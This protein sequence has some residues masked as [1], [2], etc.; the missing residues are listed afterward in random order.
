MAEIDPEQGKS[1]PIRGQRIDRTSGA[2]LP[3]LRLTAPNTGDAIR[4]TEYQG[5][6]DVQIEPLSDTESE[7][8]QIDL[9]ATQANLDAASRITHGR[10]DF[11]RL[12]DTL[13]SVTAVYSSSIGNGADEFP[14][15]QQISLPW[16][17]DVL[18]NQEF[19]PTAS[20]Q[21]SASVVCDLQIEIRENSIEGA[22]ATY[23]SFSV[24]D[25]T[26]D[27]GIITKAATLLGVTLNTWPRW[28]AKAH[29]LVVVGMNVNVRVNAQSKAALT[30][31]TVERSWGSGYSYSVDVNTKIVNIGPTIHEAL[32]FGEN[33]VEV[34]AEATADASTPTINPA[35][36]R[37]VAEIVNVITESKT[38][39][40]AVTPTGLDA[41][42]VEAIP[43]SGYYVHN[44]RAGESIYGYTE[45][46]LEIINF[47][48]V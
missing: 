35:T 5:Q 14:A 23:V 41:T 38:A 11:L 4:E 8:E 25:G 15:D 48:D 1:R 19:S 6:P 3:F 47:G 20:A 16:T 31:L 13:E 42:E 40:A 39:V 10:I 34:E 2:L 21:S 22:K 43:T 36:A 26:N 27:A 7:I 37:E 44:L 18:P 30:A 45:Y 29:S 17:G 24:P 12:P 32:D 9:E 28:G 33:F 46:Q